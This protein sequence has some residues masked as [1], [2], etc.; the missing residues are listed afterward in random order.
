[1]LSRK[2]LFAIDVGFVSIFKNKPP[3]H[4]SDFSHC[5]FTI[6]IL[7]TDAVEIAAEQS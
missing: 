1:M 6:S 4:A 2:S 5:S 3:A 7:L